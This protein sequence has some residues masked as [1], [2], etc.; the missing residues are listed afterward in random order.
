MPLVCGGVIAIMDQ[1]AAHERVQL[2]RLQHQVLS[3]FT[4]TFRRAMCT[5]SMLLACA[6]LQDSK[7]HGISRGFD[8]RTRVTPTGA[9]FE[10]RFI[11]HQAFMWLAQVIGEGGHPACAAS[12]ALR[13]PQPLD[14]SPAEAHFLESS[15]EVVEAWGWRFRLC[16]GQGEPDQ[17]VRSG[18]GRSTSAAVLTHAAVVAGVPLNATELQVAI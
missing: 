10:A 3:W 18:G 7:C 5:T 16:E 1:H 11:G 2:E 6:S 12:A 17:A 9:P 14:L 4:F 8:A 13:P 15:R